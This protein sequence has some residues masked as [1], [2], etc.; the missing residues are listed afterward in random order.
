[1]RSTSYPSYPQFSDFVIASNTCL[2]SLHRRLHFKD[3]RFIYQAQS[4]L[5]LLLCSTESI[6]SNKQVSCIGRH[7]KIE[8]V[9]AEVSVIAFTW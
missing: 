4:Y 3:P 8:K 7:H 6:A 9:K 1:M 5:K 2:I